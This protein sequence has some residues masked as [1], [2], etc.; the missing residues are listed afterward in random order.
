M[1]YTLAYCQCRKTTLTIYHRSYLSADHRVELCYMSSGPVKGFLLKWESLFLQVLRTI[2][3]ISLH[4]VLVLKRVSVGKKITEGAT[5]KTGLL[6][7]VAGLFFGRDDSTDRLKKRSE[8]MKLILH[9]VNQV[10]MC[11]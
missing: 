1:R 2:R 10:I 9:I 4:C 3:L 8:R 7:L 5:P 11:K 6:L